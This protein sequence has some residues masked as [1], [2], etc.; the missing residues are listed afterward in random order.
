MKNPFAYFTHSAGQLTVASADI[1]TL[2]FARS[3]GISP[4]NKIACSSASLQDI[5]NL[6]HMSGRILDL[7]FNNSLHRN[8]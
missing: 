4:H 2:F 3:T 6:A 7:T 5:F 1:S 8:A